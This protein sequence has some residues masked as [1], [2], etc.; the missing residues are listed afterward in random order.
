LPGNLPSENKRNRSKPQ[1]SDQQPQDPLSKTESLELIRLYWKLP[2]NDKRE[3]VM[4]MLRTLN[5][6]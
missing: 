4:K 3:L 6:Q 2:D 5:T 1:I